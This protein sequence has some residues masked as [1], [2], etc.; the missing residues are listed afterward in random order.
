MEFFNSGSP[1]NFF[2]VLSLLGGLALFLYGMNLMGEA[3]EKKAGGKL[4]TILANFTSNPFKAFILGLGVTAVIQSSSATTVMVVGF[5]NSGIMTLRQAI[6]VIM[7]AN[8]GTSVTSWLL[9]L[10][11]IDGESF[12]IQLLKPDS[13]TPVLAFIAIIMIMVFKNNS[14]KLDTAAIFIG[15]AILMYGMDF[16]SG[17]VSGLKDVPEFAQMLTLFENPILGVLAGAILTAIIQSSSASVGVLQAL[18]LTGTIS[19]ASALPIIMGQ[20][21]GTCVT[22]MLSSFGANK[23]AKRAAVVHL[24]FNVIGT[25]VWLAIYCIVTA[26]FNITFFEEN[27]VDPLAIAILHTAFNILAISIQA[28]FI[29]QLEK[30]ACLIIRDGKTKG[31]EDFELLD[32]RLLSTPTIA[33]ERSRMV[34]VKMAEASVK[35]LK[36]SLDLLFD[37][38]EKGAIAVRAG[39]DKTDKYEDSLGTYLVRVSSKSMSESD[40]HEVSKLLHMIGDFER[41]GDHAVNIIE[42]ADE[43]KNKGLAFS[44]E[45]KK[46]IGVMID[47]VKEILD[48][49]LDAFKNNDIEKAYSVEPLEEVVDTLK[50]KLKSSHVNRLRKNECTIEMG[51]VHSDLLTNLERVSDHCSNIAAC[52][53]EIAHNSFEMHGYI[54]TLD[55]DHNEIY[56]ERHAYYSEKYNLKEIS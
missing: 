32:E 38:N 47:A 30:L 9:S 37:Y 15:F 8:L 51:F 39:E 44:E 50:L 21:I 42:S 18:S 2:D 5:V 20:N 6:G 33:I 52:M 55:R 19:Y 31:N 4:K 43:V 54:N 1:F 28:P 16:M 13:F 36:M 24:C 56:T 40:S 49:S 46:E 14:K 12:L 23:N 35:T 34:A 53:I 29:K 11:G 10:A 22:A 7:G 25:I 27:F 3:L 26:V 45:A 17:A 41:I 48:L